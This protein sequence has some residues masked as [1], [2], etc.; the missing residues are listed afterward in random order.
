VGK[1]RAKEPEA[2]RLRDWLVYVIA[3]EQRPNFDHVICNYRRWL[4][5]VAR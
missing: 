4:Y 1:Q 2:T 5:E 3:S